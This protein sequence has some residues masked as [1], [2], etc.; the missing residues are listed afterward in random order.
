MGTFRGIYQHCNVSRDQL[1]Q[2]REPEGGMSQ[3]LIKIFSP[4][5]SSFPVLGHPTAVSYLQ[6]LLS[7]LAVQSHFN[8]VHS[9][10]RAHVKLSEY[11]LFTGNVC[12][13]REDHA[14]QS[15]LTCR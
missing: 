14:W 5:I 1:E 12:E 11:E 9:L 2:L 8:A 4:L 7:L 3:E 6:S 13:P 10:P 15:T